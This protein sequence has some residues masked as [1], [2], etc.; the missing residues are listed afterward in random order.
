M[1]HSPP[2]WQSPPHSAHLTPPNHRRWPCYLCNM[3]KQWQSS[4]TE[5]HFNGSRSNGSSLRKEWQSIRGLQFWAMKRHR[6]LLWPWKKTPIHPGWGKISSGNL[7][8]QT[9]PYNRSTF[10]V[11]VCQCELDR[12]SFTSILFLA[13][14]RLSASN[15]HTACLVSQEM[16]QSRISRREWPGKSFPYALVFFSSLNSIFGLFQK[17]VYGKQ[18][19]YCGRKGGTSIKALLLWIIWIWW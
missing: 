12:E 18:S 16:C 19:S 17:D 13:C 14:L 5:D 2:L 11:S 8:Q 15:L 9:K 6:P 10:S 1:N 4:Q 3:D 7:S